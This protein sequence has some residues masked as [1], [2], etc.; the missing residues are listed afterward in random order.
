MP[1][2]LTETFLRDFSTR[3][4]AAWNSHDTEQVLAL[5][6]PDVRWE[7]TIFWTGVIESREGVRAYVERIWEVMP[8]VAFDDVQTF[9]SPGDGRALCLFRQYGHGPAKLAPDATFST[10]GCDIFLGFAD[11]LLS[12]YLAQYEITEM[13]RQLGVL[14]AR[15]GRIGGAYLLSLLHRSPA[16]AG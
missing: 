9:T 10:Y 4:L 2:P 1:A 11:G 12:S 16:N 3:W 8:D 14:P 13:M 15:E 7:D 5:L 6:H